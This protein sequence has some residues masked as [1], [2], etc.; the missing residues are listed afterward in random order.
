MVRLETMVQPDIP[1][2]LSSAEDGGE[3]TEEGGDSESN[4][5]DTQEP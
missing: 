2:M 5:M 4:D 1:M 3:D